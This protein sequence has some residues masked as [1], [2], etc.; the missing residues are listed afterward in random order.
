MIPT[1]MSGLANK[2]AGNI[3]GPELWAGQTPTIEDAGGS[4]GVYDVPT[5]TMT[6]T[7]TSTTGYPRFAFDLGMSTGKRYK[8]VG[9]LSGA[10]SKLNPTIPIRLSTAGTGN[11]VPYNF[12]TGN[13][14]GIVTAGTAPVLQ[15]LSSI[16]NTEHLTIDTISV[17]E[18]L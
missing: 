14:D 15:I 16:D 1:W 5:R 8:V 3:L 2:A 4:V 18:V 6:N 9:K 13:F 17:R 12:T 10:V 7:G 11:T